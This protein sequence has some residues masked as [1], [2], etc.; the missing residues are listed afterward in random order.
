M[1]KKKK[2]S[3]E[4]KKSLLWARKSLILKNN[5]SKNNK[6]NYSDLNTKRPGVGISP[7]K[8]KEVI[9]LVACKDLKKETILKWSMLKKK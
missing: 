1:S 7:N 8:I 2:I 4:E 9:G 3:K 6:I 5:V